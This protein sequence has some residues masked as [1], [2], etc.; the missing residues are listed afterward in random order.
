MFAAS[1]GRAACVGALSLLL[2]LAACSSQDGVAPVFDQ[3]DIDAGDLDIAYRTPTQ[4]AVPGLNVEQLTPGRRFVVYVPSSYTPEQDWPVLMLLHGSGDRGSTIVNSLAVAAEAE[5]VVLIAPDAARYTWDLILGNVGPD[6]D[7]IERLVGWAYDHIQVDPQ[8][9]AIGGFSD[10]G[11][12]SAWL[13]LLN[14]DLFRRILVLSGCARFPD[15]G[16]VG[17]PSLLILH[18]NNDPLFG[19][20]SCVPLLLPDLQLNGYD[21]EFLEFQGRHEV[22]QEFAQRAMRFIAAQ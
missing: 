15:E 17:R 2:S 7:Y 21:V 18:G 13:G 19:R 14:G 5:G 20:D 9:L 22:S 10:G 6:A 11:T 12:Y 8:R 1:R 4:G 3:R 16:R